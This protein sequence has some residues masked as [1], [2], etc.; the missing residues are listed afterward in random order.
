MKKFLIFDGSAFLYRAFY[1]LPPLLAPDGTPTGAIFG[2][3]K[4][5]NKLISLLSPAHVA[6]VW[7]AGHSGRDKILPTYKANR[8]KMPDALSIQYSLVKPILNDLGVANISVQGF[9]ADDVIFA[10]TKKFKDE[11]SFVIASSDKDLFQLVGENVVMFDPI[12]Q[13]EMGA[14]YCEA[15]FGIKP[16][17]IRFYHALLG[18]SSDNIDG[19]DGIGK[20]TALKLALQFESMIDMYN[21]LEM[22]SSK[23]VHQALFYQREK[24]FLSYELF[25]LQDCDIQKSLSDFVFDKLD[26]S[27]AREWVDK[28]GMHSL[29][30][31]TG[32]SSKKVDASEIVWGSGRGFKLINCDQDFLELSEKFLSCQHLALDSETTGFKWKSDEVFGVSFAC[33][34]NEGFFVTTDVLKNNVELLRKVL[35]SGAKKMFHNAKFDLHFLEQAFDIKTENVYFDTAIAARLLYPEW[36]KIGLKNLVE[37]EFKIS[38]AD[39]SDLLS[40]FKSIQNMP[41]E[42]L[43]E[44]ACADATD[45]FELFKLLHARLDEQGDPLKKIFYEIEMPLSEILLKME[46]AGVLL[47]VEKL[48][49]I[50][51]ALDKKLQ[52]L[53][54]D[55]RA[56][57]A[58]Y[59]VEN[60]EVL[61]FNSPKQLAEV[62]FDKLK[63]EST[64]TSD[65]GNRSTNEEVLQDLSKQHPLPLQIL[66]FRA[67]TKLRSTYVEGLLQAADPKTNKVHT[68]FLQNSVATGR[69]ASNDPNLQNLPASGA[70]FNIRSCFI[71]APGNVLISADYSQ[72]ELRV[73]AQITKDP[74]LS[75]AFLNDEDIH[76]KTAALMFKVAASDVTAEQRSIAKTINFSI[77]YGKTAFTLAKD[78]NISPKEASIYISTFFENYL[79]IKNWMDFVVQDAIKHGY[80]KTILGRR[81]YFAN[82]EDRNKNIA[83]A[84]QRAAINSVVQG[85]AAEL[86]KMAM[87]KIDNELKKT[88]FDAKMLLQIHD[89]LVFECSEK[90]LSAVLQLVE[91][92]MKN[93]VS[94]DIPVLVNLKIGKNLGELKKV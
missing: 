53:D 22:V 49:Q 8:D 70:E 66:E 81:R 30:S 7:D 82:L 69:L 3:L 18:D 93:V 60:F 65:K 43:T 51:V 83:Q 79:S 27:K 74:G 56:M 46:A 75:Q 42:K 63:L 76:Q 78:L 31:A 14:L 44:Y 39:F 86:I 84:E 20:T 77:L 41:V 64:K 88:G 25:G 17:K 28:Y 16:E 58:D 15:K 5:L 33:S 80:T 59:E 67:A 87:I 37:K 50:G 92:C 71:S 45:T 26:F 48:R 55:M 62:L 29:L 32:R 72:I 21:N 85:S 61:N 91:Q 68:T 38:R 6:V 4:S 57:L 52:S 34:E 35:Q 54:R 13:V 10:L 89:E 2:F 1:A 24:A 12:K 19:V 11:A 40:V 94:W 23:K 90:D 9:E 73:L 36:Q 47:D